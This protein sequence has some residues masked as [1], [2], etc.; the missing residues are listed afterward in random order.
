MGTYYSFNI[1][2]SVHFNGSGQDVGLVETRLKNSFG[3][4]VLAGTDLH[5][6]GKFYKWHDAINEALFNTEGIIVRVAESNDS[7]DGI[8]YHFFTSEDGFLY[9]ELPSVPE[10]NIE[11]AETAR[12]QKELDAKKAAA[13]KARA[14]KKLTKEER[15]VLGLK[16]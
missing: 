1:D 8:R 4:D 2:I 14:I 15:E 11:K 16:I 7:D 6:C 5:P 9:T 13:I 3:V 12:K 10:F